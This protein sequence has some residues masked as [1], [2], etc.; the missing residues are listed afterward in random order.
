MPHLKG[1][2]ETKERRALV[3]E[4]NKLS[5]SQLYQKTVSEINSASV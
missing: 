4:K 3:S 5:E 2:R 1:L